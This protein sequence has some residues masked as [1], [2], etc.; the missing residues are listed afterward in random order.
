MHTDYDRV[1][2]AIRFIDQHA[3]DQPDLDAV[4]AHISLSPFHFQRL[5]RRWVGISPKRFLQL[6]TL[7][8]AKLVLAQ[9]RSLL[10]AAYDTG[11]SSPGRLHDLFVTLD[12]VTPG[13]F[14]RRAEGLVIR[15][16][17]HESPFGNCLLAVT[18]RGVCGLSFHDDKACEEERERLL[19]AWPRARIVDDPAATSPVMAR[20]FDSAHRGDEQPTR[21]L[22]KG[23]NFQAKVWQALLRIRPGMLAAYGDVARWVGS[24][25]SSRAVGA[26]VGRNPVAYL[27]PCHRV[28]RKLG[29]YGGYRWGTTRKRAIIGWELG[30]RID[31]R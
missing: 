28:V 6:T 18:D 29:A 2:A 14:K 7:Q 16:G 3:A 13:E 23:T 26:A 1:A 30:R 31:D 10:D 21:L 15:T 17:V 24:P 11:L 8:H 22:V 5:F 12:A 27:I 20:I 9:S 4:A 19:A 25:S